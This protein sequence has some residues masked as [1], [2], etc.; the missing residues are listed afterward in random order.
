[1]S[2]LEIS[3]GRVEEDGVG[4]VR[5]VERE[6]SWKADANTHYDLPFVKPSLGHTPNF[7]LCWLLLGPQE[8]RL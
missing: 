6:G 3:L 2:L 7:C 4:D 5:L 1:M 8:R